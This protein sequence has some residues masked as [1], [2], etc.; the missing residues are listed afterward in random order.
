[1]RTLFLA[2]FAL[3][4]AN[5][6]VAQEATRIPIPGYEGMLYCRSIDSIHAIAYAGS[7]P[8][9][10]RQAEDEHVRRHACERV[11]ESESTVFYVFRRYR[12]E[13]ERRNQRSYGV[14]E[15]D[16]VVE[17]TRTERV[18]FLS[19]VQPPR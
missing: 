1:M 15:L 11:R 8:E 18:Y 16:R 13:P 14:F 3:M 17:G 6:A 2:S 19:D 10:F 7:S 9:T 5:V 4:C 12:F